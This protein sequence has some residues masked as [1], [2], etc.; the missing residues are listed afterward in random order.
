MQLHAKSYGQDSSPPLVILHGLFGSLDNW[1]G[2]SN[3]LAEHFKV[4]T[5]DLRNHGRSDWSEQ[6][7]YPAM[8]DDLLAFLDQ[9]GLD[10]I[11]LLGHSM[12]GKVAMQFALD[13]PQRVKR[14]IVVDIS[15]VRYPPHHTDVF[16]GLRGVELG[17]ISSR[18]EADQ[19]LQ[20]QI[21][22]T[23]IR[24]FL[25]KNLYRDGERFN[26]RANLEVL[27]REYDYIAS[28]PAPRFEHQHFEAPTLFIKGA[29]SHYI[30]AEHRPAIGALFPNAEA[31]IMNGVGH[32]PHAEK[33]KAFNALLL[34]FLSPQA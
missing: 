17:S 29:E 12:G 31:R 4:W 25:L 11:D 3:V 28:P 32:W 22:D 33:P 2:Q 14:L 30:Q 8:A 6:M 13:Y 18:R 34:R 23:S 1:A 27:E 10:S 19:Q 24:N 9:Q 15:P 7:S 26:W 20:Q 21:E 5:L 16:A